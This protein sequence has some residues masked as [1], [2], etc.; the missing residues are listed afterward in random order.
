MGKL[1]SYESIYDVNT[2]L[3][4]AATEL[5]ITLKPNAEKIGLTLGEISRQLRQ[6]YYGEEVQRLPREGDDVKV[7]VH[8]PKKLRRS[9]DS[10]TKFR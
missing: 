6:A 7:M 5:Q 9:V 1:R 4:S 3:N 8:Y 2:S 10:L